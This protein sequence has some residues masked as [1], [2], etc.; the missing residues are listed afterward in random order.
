VSTGDE[1]EVLSGAEGRSR[2]GR[3]I[4]Q[5]LGEQAAE[6]FTNLWRALDEWDHSRHPG[7]GLRERKKRLTRQR[8]SDVATALFVSRGF[9]NV[10][11]SE[12]ADTVGVSEKTIYNYFP[13]KESLVFDNADEQ[14]LRLTAAVRDRPQ[15]TSPTAAF[16]SELKLQVEDFNA[17]AGDVR[18]DF[19][20]PF[21]EM[22]HQTPSLRAAWGEHRHRLVEALTEVL[23]AEFGVNPLDPEPL[24]A[25]RALVSLQEIFFDS[26]TRHIE[27]GIASGE[28][29]DAIAADI[30]R[31]ARL[32]ETGFWSI[33]LLLEGRRTKQQLRDAAVAAEQARQQVLA[34]VR[35]AKR[36]WRD[37]RSD[38]R[39]AGREARAS[40]RQQAALA[41]EAARA[42]PRRLKGR[43]K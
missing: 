36:A 17:V 43:G 23:A 22:V 19:L 4:A 18:V 11:V 28:L 5:E 8:I 16:V 7:E 31:G 26:L 9:D 37:V 25:A 2:I 41:R 38:A 33:Q 27:D 39:A 1:E 6:T 3:V 12:I 24:V 32:L 42:D 40:A 29:A 21:A 10:T 35:D 34:A 15:G 14:L 13:T 30:D 20:M